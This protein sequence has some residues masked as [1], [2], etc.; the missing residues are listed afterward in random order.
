[1]KKYF[2]IAK[3]TWDEVTGYRLNF[4]MWRVRNVLQI[5]T[6]YFL[7]SSILSAQTSFLGYDKSNML[8]YVLGTSLIT[9]I[10]LSSRSFDVGDAITSGDLSG[11]LIRPINYFS[12][13]FAKDIG[14]KAM[15]VA[16]SIVELFIL[17]ILLRPPLFIQTNPLLIALA[18]G[19]ALIGVLLYFFFN[20]LLGFIGFWSSETW[21]PRFIFTILINFFAGGLFPLDLLPGPAYAIFKLMP[22]SYLL[23][24]PMKVYLGRLP[25]PEVI[26]GIVVSIGWIFIMLYCVKKIWAKGLKVYTAYGR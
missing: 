10:V 14:D 7:W 13:L 16:F 17:F 11:F 25:L 8:T 5:L 20:L 3:N 9:S 26:Q 22:F 21:A 2:Q 15:N 12:Y 1:M 18:C 24:F 19:S 4:V 6:L 23:Y